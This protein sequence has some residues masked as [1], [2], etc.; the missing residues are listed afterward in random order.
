MPDI[1]FI[2]QIV[3]ETSNSQNSKQTLLF[4]INSDNEYKRFRSSKVNFGNRKVPIPSKNRYTNLDS[5][6]INGNKLYNYLG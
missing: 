4:T 5:S 2:N 3:I 1:K 6:K